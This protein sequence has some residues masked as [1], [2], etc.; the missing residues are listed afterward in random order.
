M[1]FDLSALLPILAIVVSIGAAVF[2]DGSDGKGA[3][4]E[5]FVSEIVLHSKKPTDSNQTIRI[6]RVQIEPGIRLKSSDLRA[7]DEREGSSFVNG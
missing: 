1:S 7:R 2:W 4:V 3:R 5:R 6:A